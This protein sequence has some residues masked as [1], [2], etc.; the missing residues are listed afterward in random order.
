MKNYVIFNG[1]STEDIALIEELPVVS[2]AE[3]DI[4]FIEID[5]RHGFLTFDKN[6][7]KPVDYSIE[8]KVNGKANRDLIRNIFIGNGDLILSNESDRYYKAVIT[9][10]VT[11]ERQLKELYKINVSFKLQPFSYVRAKETVVI[12][13]TPYIIDNPTNTTSQP[14]IKIYGSGMSYLNINGNIIEL[15]NIT[16]D[17]LILDFELKE[18]YD[19][20]KVSK[21]TD[22]FGVYKEFIVGSNTISWTDNITKIEVTPNWRYL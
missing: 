6:R 2:R 20:N 9:G 8:L 7:Y 5:G 1:K 18:A 17:G 10:T 4:D 14:I 11:V 22:V 21:N 19:F 12:T 3:R 15:K 13:A 16:S